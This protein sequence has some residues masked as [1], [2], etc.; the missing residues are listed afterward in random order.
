MKCLFILDAEF[1]NVGPHCLHNSI[2]CYSTSYF[3]STALSPQ[4]FCKTLVTKLESNKMKRR[5]WLS[6]KPFFPL[7]AMRA[8]W[9]RLG[10]NQFCCRTFS[11]LSWDFLSLKIICIIPL[12]LSIFCNQKFGSNREEMHLPVVPIWVPTLYLQ[13]EKEVIS[14][15]RLL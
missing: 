4:H 9:E 1:E 11:S 2:F 6:G 10:H 12:T 5:Q 15:A 7:Y 14:Y 13:K 8:L 3:Q